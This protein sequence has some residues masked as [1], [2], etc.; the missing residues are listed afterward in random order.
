MKLTNEGCRLRQK[1]LLSEMEHHGICVSIIGNPKNVLYLT[2]YTTHPF[3][4][5]AVILDLRGRCTL[6]APETEE[7][8]SADHF[9]PLESSSLST[10]RPDMHS[11]AAALVRNNLDRS[12][13]EIGLDKEGSSCYLGDIAEQIID[14]TP[15][16]LDLRRSKYPDEIELLKRGIWIAELCYQRAR[17]IIEP[18][19]TEL[20]IYSDL[21]Q[22]AVLVSGERLPAMGNDFRCGE[23]GG[24]PR[25]RKIESGELYILDLGVEFGGYFSDTCRTFAV[26]RDPSEIQ[27]Q[28]W[29]DLTAVFQIVE[30]T[31]KPG[32]S[33]RETYE[34]V[35]TKL[36]HNWPKSFSHHLGHGI[37]LSPHERPYL[38]PNWNQLFQVGDVFTVEP[39]IYGPDLKGGIR[40]EEN[41]IVTDDGIE[42][43]TQHPINL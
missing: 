25:R 14:L 20:E 1:K 37:G 40:I 10:I 18:G 12:D 43:I 28:A 31:V 2:G 36:D 30:D 19:V 27:L 9:I 39:G 33:C 7:D 41:Y 21:Y 34:S 29:R 35:K 32:V 38:N 22:T 4:S 26:N 6:I 42:K 23:A 8:F 16:L 5:S 13:T 11:A 3:H 17:E 24:P 15:I